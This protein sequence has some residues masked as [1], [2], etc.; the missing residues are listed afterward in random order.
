M[1][2]KQ[3]S[4]L[5]A[6]LTKQYSDEGA[7]HSKTSHLERIMPLLQS[8]QNLEIEA[9]TK[10]NGA[11]K[12]GKENLDAKIEAADSSL[13]EKLEKHAGKEKLEEPAAFNP[14]KI[15]FTPPFT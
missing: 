10:V 14:P 1:D 12:N 11:I 2:L 9:T 3:V 5:V 15:D 7:E 13:K 6:G 4:D 8:A